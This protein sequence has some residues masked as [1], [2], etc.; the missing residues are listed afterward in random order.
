VLIAIANSVPSKRAFSAMNYIHN[1]LRNSLIVE[2]ANKLSFIQI[3]LG[4]ITKTTKE[5]ELEQRL[6]EFGEEFRWFYKQN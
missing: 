3:N 6:Q 2:R 5:Q 1:K 4:H